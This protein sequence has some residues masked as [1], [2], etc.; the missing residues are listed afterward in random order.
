[1]CRDLVY[2]D[3]MEVDSTYYSDSESMDKQ[4]VPIVTHSNQSSFLHK[5]PFEVFEQICASLD[6]LWLLNLSQTCQHMHERLSFEQ[7]NKI[8]Y[9]SLPSS[10]WKEAEHYQDETELGNLLASRGSPEHVVSEMVVDFM[11]RGPLPI[12][13]SP[14]KSSSESAFYG[15]STLASPLAPPMPIH[16]INARTMQTFHPGYDLSPTRSK[17]GGISTGISSAGLSGRQHVQALGRPYEPVFNYKREIVGYLKTSQRCYI[18]LN[19]KGPAGESVNTWRWGILF[20]TECLKEHTVTLGA[21]RKLAHVPGVRSVLDHVSLVPYQNGSSMVFYRP[22]VDD[23]IRKATGLYLETQLLNHKT[24]QQMTDKVRIERS[25][26]EGHRRIVRCLVVAAAELLWEGYD[27]S[28]NET[29]DP[30]TGEVSDWQA[31][32][33]MDSSDTFKTFRDRFAPTYKL[34]T[35]LFPDYL[36]DEFPTRLAYNP[37]SGWMEDPTMLLR[38]KEH[39]DD[40]TER[41]VADKAFE[42]LIKLTDWRHTNYYLNMEHVPIEL[43]EAAGLRRFRKL[44]AKCGLQEEKSA[45][46]HPLPQRPERGGFVKQYSFEEYVQLDQ[47]AAA[48]EQER[49][50]AIKYFNKIIRHTCVGCPETALLFYPMGF[51]AL[52][53]HMRFAHA[54]RFWTKDDFHTIG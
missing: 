43:R 7:G 15:S 16:S 32:E 17:Y 45:T 14:H 30:E 4:A 18:C 29:K 50:D 33:G 10:V 54:R 40:L 21:I 19:L 8:W 5:V 41:W 39:F 2:S 48:A 1:M 51:E 34:K 52:V 31:R 35:F 13:S 36:L 20:C 22:E 37:A 44:R 28:P 23:L 27:P 3:A 26:L 46:M 12:A 38:K 11:Y 53:E 25:G 47:L 24:R 42:M 49:A 9:N 6:P